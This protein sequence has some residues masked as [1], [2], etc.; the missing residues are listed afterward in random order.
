M[1]SDREDHHRRG[2]HH[3]GGAPAPALPAVRALGTLA[4]RM[5]A[6]IGDHR[7]GGEENG[8]GRQPHL[9]PV[10]LPVLMQRGINL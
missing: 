1:Y 8:I 5:E 6:E 4:D 9:D 3:G 10:G 7:L 2:D